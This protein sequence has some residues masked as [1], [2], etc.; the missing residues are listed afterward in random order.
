MTE[1]LCLPWLAK[2]SLQLD[3]FQEGVIALLSKVFKAPIWDTEHT[4]VH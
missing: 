3:L 4:A 2:E 1:C